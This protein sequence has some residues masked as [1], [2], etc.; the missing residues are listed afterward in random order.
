MSETAGRSDMGIG[1]ALLFGALAVVAAGGMAVTV[2]TQVVAAWSFA[3][4]VV[5]G[6]LS[7]AVLHLYGDNR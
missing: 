1:L 7:V 5:A 4:A 3:G 2:E 6:T